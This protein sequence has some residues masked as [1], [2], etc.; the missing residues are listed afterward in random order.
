[1][2]EIGENDRVEHFG[3]RVGFDPNIGPCALVVKAAYV[4]FDTKVVDAA[5]VGAV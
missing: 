1:L 3:E 2:A 4:F 5:L